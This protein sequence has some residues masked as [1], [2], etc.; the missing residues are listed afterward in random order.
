M[1]N[2]IIRQKGKLLVYRGEMARS[3]VQ[4]EVEDKDLQAFEIYLETQGINDYQIE[5]I[6]DIGKIDIEE[7]KKYKGLRTIRTNNSPKGSLRL[8][9]K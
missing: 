4:F 8:S 6:E 5:P 3:P 9:I 7:K 1:V 2:V